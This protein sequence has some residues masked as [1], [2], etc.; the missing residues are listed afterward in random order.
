MRNFFMLLTMLLFFSCSKENLSSS[1][2][3]LGDENLQVTEQLLLT[4]LVQ[5]GE[6]ITSP[7]DEEDV[8][9]IEGENTFS[10]KNYDLI[11]GSCE[12]IANIH[13]VIDLDANTFTDS[14]GNEGEIVLSGSQVELKY[15]G[16]LEGVVVTY[17]N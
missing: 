6:D 10:L 13:G 1:E 16:D 8:F 11:D 5:N 3:N 2:N 15:S 4:S 9:I 14:Y 7:C 12:L 17:N